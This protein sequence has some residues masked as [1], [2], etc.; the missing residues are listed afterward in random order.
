MAKK[1]LTFFGYFSWMVVIS[2]FIYGI[3]SM[4]LVDKYRAYT[5]GTTIRRLYTVK[6]GWQIE[7]KYIIN[8]VEYISYGYDAPKYHIAY[9]NGRYI[10]RFSY[11]APGIGT[12]PMWD[13]KLSDTS[14]LIAP[15][16]GWR[17]V[18]F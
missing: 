5:I 17:S 18:P 2:V 14:T 9:P 7:F 12:R 13:K 6:Q 15:P 4:Y 16:E 3:S 10:I 11:K 8:G 1:R